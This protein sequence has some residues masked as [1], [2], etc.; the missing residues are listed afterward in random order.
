MSEKDKNSKESATAEPAPTV[1]A[2][3]VTPTY[4]RPGWTHPTNMGKYFDPPEGFHPTAHILRLPPVIPTVFVRPLALFKMFV[5]VGSIDL[6]VGWLGICRKKKTNYVI[7]DVFLFDQEVSYGHTEI[8]TETLNNTRFW[9]HSHGAGGTSPSSRDNEQMQ[10]FDALRSPFFVRGIFNRGGD[11][12]FGV[13]DYENNMAY[14]NVPWIST[15]EKLPDMEVL[16]RIYLEL[17][18]EMRARVVR[19]STHT[20]T[21]TKRTYTYNNPITNLFGYWG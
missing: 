9:G 13:Y 16:N 18:A 3:P 15:G 11:V 1:Q 20:Y 14:H 10:L 2:Y 6:E 17:R 8:S 12:T 21:P 4:R 19:K 7:E 5:Y